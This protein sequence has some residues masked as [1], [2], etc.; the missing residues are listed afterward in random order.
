MANSVD[1]IHFE[2]L[3]KQEPEDVCRRSLCSYDDVKN[4]YVLSAWGDQYAIYPNEY[5]AET[6]SE[7]AEPPHEFFYLFIMH[8]L[9]NSKEIE[10][11][12]EW[13]SEK[14]IPGGPTFFRGPH[15]IPGHLISDLYMND[16]DKFD[17]RC[18]Q[19]HGIPIDMGDAAYRF[20]ITPRIPVVVLYWKGDKDF[21]PESKILYDQTITK[22]LATDIVFSLAVEIC[23]R[24]GK[25]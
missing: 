3:A 7:N 23:A 2:D 13:I 12:N 24:I 9:L 8:Y 5:I 16:L 21:P 17:N 6:V 14:D 19:L 15:E 1:R 22:H 4:C 20:D 18:R 10:V 11:K 25:N